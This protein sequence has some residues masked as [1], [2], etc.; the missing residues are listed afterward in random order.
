MRDLTISV[1]PRRDS[2]SWQPRTVTW[3]DIV[4]QLGAVKRTRETVAEYRAMSKPEKAA[5]KDIGG[6]VGGS[7]TGRRIASAVP[8]TWTT[9]PRGPWTPSGS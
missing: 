6:F 3:E 7:V 1:A 4:R 9:H 8:S 2:V 5:A